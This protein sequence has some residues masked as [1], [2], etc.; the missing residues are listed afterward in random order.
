MVFDFPLKG[1]VTGNLLTIMGLLY[2]GWGGG[3]DLNFL[4]KKRENDMKSAD[5]GCA[6]FSAFF[7]VGWYYIPTIHAP[8]IRLKAARVSC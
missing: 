1:R 3:G 7:S 8:A 4:Y 5:N 2:T 6:S